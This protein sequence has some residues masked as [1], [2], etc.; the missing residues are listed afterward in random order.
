VPA[1]ERFWSKV[2]VRGDDECWNWKGARTKGRSFHHYGLFRMSRK[3]GEK[4]GKVERA[5]R[6]ALVLSGVEIPEGEVVRHTCDNHLCVNPR[7]LI[8]GSNK[9]NYE[10]GRKRNRIRH[11]ERGNFAPLP[12]ELKGLE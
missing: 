8:L 4:E 7:H 5:H 3:P 6:A 1:L 9:D 11:N 12:D 10:D 2:D